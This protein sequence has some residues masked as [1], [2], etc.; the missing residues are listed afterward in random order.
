M[1]IRKLIHIILGIYLVTVMIG[2][3]LPALAQDSP[4]DPG[5]TIE[6]I[7]LPRAIGPLGLA[8]APDG[9]VWYAEWG[10]NAIGR[11]RMSGE[12]TEYPTSANNTVNVAVGSDGNIWFTISQYGEGPIG[13]IGRIT[14]DGMMVEYPT[15]PWNALS[16]PHNLT[17]GPDGNI[18]FT[19]PNISMIGRITPDGSFSGFSV[20]TAGAHGI[21]AG[22]DGNIWFTG[23]GD[24][25]VGKITLDGQFTG[26]GV[27]SAGP[28]EIIGGPDGN[29]W[30][31]EYWGPN[32]NRIT[33]D[34]TI[35]RFPIS[36]G[37]GT[38]GITVG[39]DGNIWFT[40]PQNNKIGRI[41]PDGVMTEYPI[42]TENSWPCYI[43]SGPDGTLWFTEHF[44]NKIGKIIINRPPA[45]SGISAPLNPV[46]LG[47]SINATA[48][49]SDPD[50]G[51]SHTVTWDWGDGNTTTSPAAKPEVTIAH[52]YTSAGVYTIGATIKDKAGASASATYQYV[53][54]YDPNGGFVTGGG[55]VNSPAGA[56]LANPDLTGKA[57]F[58][59]VSRYKKGASVPDGDTEFQF[60]AAGLNFKSASYDWLV[61]AGSKAQYKGTGTINGAGLY[62]F[63]LTARDSSPDT[64]RIKIWDKVSGSLVYDNML[65]TADGADPTT[66]LGGGSIVI[67]K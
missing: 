23:Y 10:G 31:T 30:F 51:D 34:G 18:W 64:F 45:V 53:V 46:Q 5:I 63:M 39:V 12:F 61:I 40:E 6:E 49:F 47:Q 42:A 41:T 27:G 36:S 62:T 67:H 4:P 15:P 35:T 57:T 29:V 56:S 25:S 43:T 44:G 26:Y 22:P 21:A 28:F 54:I 48:T 1:N 17:L 9:D 32:V 33:P 38:R 11:Y 50:A 8:V 13:S 3:P 19:Q 66:A 37:V 20:P 60:H 59:F 2:Q 14:P 24:G 58:G 55:W 52:T 7:T 16:S 65:G